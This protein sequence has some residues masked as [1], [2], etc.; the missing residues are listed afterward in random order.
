MKLKELLEELKNL[1]EDTDII[2]NMAVGCCSE[3]E[4]LPLSDIDTDTKGYVTFWLDCPDFLNSCR[5][6]GAAIRRSD[7]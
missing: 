2:F 7:A 1:P 6:Y 4:Y 5:K 3:V